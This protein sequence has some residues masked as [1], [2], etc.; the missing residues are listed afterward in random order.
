VV[1]VDGTFFVITKRVLLNTTADDF[2]RLCRIL[3]DKREVLFI[4]KLFFDKGK[5]DFDDFRR[6][7]NLQFILANLT[8]RQGLELAQRVFSNVRKEIER[9][10]SQKYNDRYTLSPGNVL[11]SKPG[12]VD[13]I[14]HRDYELGVCKG[15]A[16][17]IFIA[18]QDCKLN[19]A[20]GENEYRQRNIY[21]GN[22]LIFDGT[23]IHGGCSYNAYNYR[24]HFYALTDQ[25]NHLMESV[26]STTSIVDET[27][28]S[29]GGN[30]KRGS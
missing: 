30:R 28:Y 11:M 4:E 3:H 27:F 16:L 17:I 15:L 9:Y 10:I 7:V 26:Q 14:M 12:G 23:L 2:A 22:V 19:I 21:T 20:C 13:Q 5:K 1:G 18:L 6:Q 8:K 25:D 29:A 24:L